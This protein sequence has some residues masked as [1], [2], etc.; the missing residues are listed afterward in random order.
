MGTAYN[1]GRAKLSERIEP[2]KRILSQL[3][4]WAS[5]NRFRHHHALKVMCGEH[6]LKVR[7]RQRLDLPA[8]MA[9]AWNTMPEY[10]ALASV[11]VEE[12]ELVFQDQKEIILVSTQSPTWVDQVLG[13]LGWLL[14][15]VVLPLGD[16]SEWISE[17]R[18]PD[19]PAT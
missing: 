16:P 8:W 19:G 7:A 12:G 11:R 15:L 18:A 5:N 2:M 17:E 10:R 3:R 6:T 14:A 1:R 4:L 13:R 9:L